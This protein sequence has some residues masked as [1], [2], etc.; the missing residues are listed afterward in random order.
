MPIKAFAVLT[1]RTE[2]WLEANKEEIIECFAAYFVEGADR[3]D[4]A[5]EWIK[6]AVEIVE[7]EQGRD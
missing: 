4:D 6:N 2:A 1:G 5:V 3:R 7:E